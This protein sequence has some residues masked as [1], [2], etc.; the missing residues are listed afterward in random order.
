[1]TDVDDVVRDWA[2]FAIATQCDAD[3][4]DLRG[5]LS[6]RLADS[7]DETRGEA[8]VGL[9]RRGDTSVI[10]AVPDALECGDPGQLVFDAA[11]AILEHYPQDER[12]STPE[13]RAQIFSVRSS[14]E[15]QT[16]EVQ[17][18]P[19]SRIASRSPSVLSSFPAL[20]QSR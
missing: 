20:V 8:M 16:S 12:I 13:S 9:A 14:S 17:R 6:A 7:D 15:A 1:M 18:R 5:A 19:L 11:Q 4:A 10:S 3:A 2:T